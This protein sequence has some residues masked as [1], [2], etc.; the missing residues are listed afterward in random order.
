M[1]PEWISVSTGY[2]GYMIEYSTIVKQR[3]PHHG[4][5]ILSAE[6]EFVQPIDRRVRDFVCPDCTEAYKAY[7]RSARK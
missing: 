4:E 5:V 2:I 6:R 3:F 7:W 1:R